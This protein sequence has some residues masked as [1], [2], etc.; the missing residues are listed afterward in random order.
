MRMVD[1]LM[2]QQRRIVRAVAALGPRG[3]TSRVPEGVRAE[4][5]AYAHSR[6]VDG[7]SWGAIAEEI[8]FSVTAVQNWAAAPARRMLLPVAV[9]PE[10]A[11][12]V[13]PPVLVLITPAG[14]RVEGLDVSTTVALVRA[15]A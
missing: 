14:L 5:A 9:R 10:P 7:A 8:G 3:R 11:G 2:A 15:L 1:M 4:I 6:R 12:S 13:A